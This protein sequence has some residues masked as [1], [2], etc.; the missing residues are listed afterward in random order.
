MSSGAVHPAAAGAESIH[1][2]SSRPKSF[3]IPR[4]MM[5]AVVTA[6][7]EIDFHE[8]AVAKPGR[9]EILVRLEGCGICASNIPP[10]QGKPWFNYPLAPGQLGHEGW[11]R[12]EEIG[13]DVVG[14]AAG[15]RVGLISNNAYAPFDVAAAASTVL[16]PRALD[17]EPFPAEPLGCAMNIFQ[18]SGIESDDK[19]AIVGI[20]FLGALLTQLAA[21]AGAQVIAI[22]RRP[23]ALQLAE[24][25]G[26]EK[27]ILM[28]DHAKIIEEVSALTDGRFCDVVIEATGKQWPLDLSAELTK[29]RGRLVLAGYHQDGPRQVNMQLWNWRG[30]DVI[31]AHER[32]PSVYAEGV[33][34]AIEAVQDG[35][36][37]PAP[38]YTHR[39]PL[40]RLGEALDATRDRPDGFLKALVVPG[41]R[42]SLQPRP[43]PAF[44]PLIAVRGSASWASV[45]SDA[46]VWRRCSAPA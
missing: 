42:R 22:G 45:G 24:K 40:E 5:A 8:V 14:F 34:E 32:D 29:E 4:T 15:D 37:D 39:H 2:G 36:I 20:G 23:F 3:Q 21:A 30:L 16:L 27:T 13:E 19:V 35:R 12:V 31:N 9:D 28:N 1:P 17:A 18:R 46:T 25:M 44:Q 26:A 41:A 43:P 7:G 33:R 11:G 38:L 6:P 10:W